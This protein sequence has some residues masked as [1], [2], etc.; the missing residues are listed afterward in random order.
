MSKPRRILEL[1]ELPENAAGSPVV[2]RD[3]SVTLGY[4]DGTQQTFNSHE[5]GG[6]VASCCGGSGPCNPA[7]EQCPE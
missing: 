2:T 3:M 1:D 4:A 7:V 5:G 6:V